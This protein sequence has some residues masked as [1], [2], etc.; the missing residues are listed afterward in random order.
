[1]SSNRTARLRLQ[2]K[3]KLGLFT[4]L[5]TMLTAGIPLLEAIRSLEDDAKGNLAKVLSE[6]H[7]SLNNGETLSLAMSRLP[8]AF[9][10]V[11]IN[12]V[13]A[14]ENGGTLEDTLHDIVIA[15]RKEIAFSDQL[16]NTMIYPIFVM[17]VFLGI[18][19]LM[20]T[21][22]IP[23]VASVFSTMRVN[24][25]WITRQMIVASNFFM[26]HWLV[27]VIGLIVI[28]LLISWYVNTHR[29]Q[30]IRLL[31]GLPM[32]RSLGTNIDLTRFTRSFGLLMRAGV[33]IIEA[34]SLSE[35]VVQKKSIIAVIKQMQNDVNNGKPLATSLR[36]SKSVI[37][38]IMSR[39]IETAD[40]SGTLDETLQNLTDYFDGQ[41]T[42]SLKVLS[43]L[44]EPVLLIIVGGM[45][46]LLMITIIAPIYNM[47][48]QINP[49]QK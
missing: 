18:V 5:S 40:T 32:L 39:S 29:R 41:V 23:R 44:I 24:M 37:P 4:D 21:F 30:I 11:N 26:S 10:P 16:R 35:K 12:L 28:I 27:L 34:L 36:H 45:V 7:R 31:L 13:R 33:P 6:L 46:G 42:Q 20:L 25:P 22:V 48:S 8:L 38:I 1:M 49:S 14:A 3:E 43:S 17:V 9:D 19:I 2:A 47:I 15:T